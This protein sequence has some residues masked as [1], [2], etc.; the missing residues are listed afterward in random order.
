MLC[1]NERSSRMMYLL[2]PSSMV[3]NCESVLPF[4]LFLVGYD[5]MVTTVLLSPV[6]LGLED[7]PV[8]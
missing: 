1:P 5:P 3:S 7:P 6:F 8:G 2:S 4:L